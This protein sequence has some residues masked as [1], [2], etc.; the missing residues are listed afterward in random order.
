MVSRFQDTITWPVILTGV[1]R[2]H[3]LPT[4]LGT[5]SPTQCQT[6]GNVCRWRNWGT[7]VTSGFLQ[8]SSPASI[9]ILYIPEKESLCL[10]PCPE[11]PA[12]KRKENPWPGFH[13]KWTEILAFALIRILRLGIRRP[14]FAPTASCAILE[15]SLSIH[16]LHLIPSFVKWASYTSLVS[17][18]S[19]LKYSK[20]EHCEAA[21]G[22]LDISCSI[23]FSIRLC[24]LVCI[25]QLFSTHCAPK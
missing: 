7:S 21:G 8:A 13:L 20:K 22:N 23:N 12:W 9:P 10:C 5:H 15:K 24:F 19:G 18:C 4:S 2:E 25:V 16:Q 14:G 17:F 1:S 11:A 3:P 6:I